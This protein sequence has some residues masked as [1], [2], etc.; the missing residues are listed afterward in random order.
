MEQ[1]VLVVGTHMFFFFLLRPPPKKSLSCTIKKK[2]KRRGSRTTAWGHRSGGRR[3]PGVL[4]ERAVG[5]KRRTAR[6]S[7]VHHSVLSLFQAAINLS[8]PSSTLLNREVI[9]V[10]VSSTF[11]KLSTHSK[12]REREWKK[13]NHNRASIITHNV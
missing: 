12:E 3:R 13:E 11:I 6:P 8:L 2:K 1:E 10:G 5:Y 7:S 4:E 9:L